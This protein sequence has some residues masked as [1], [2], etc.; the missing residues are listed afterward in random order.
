MCMFRSV[1]LE[2][3]Q[4]GRFLLSFM[5]MLTVIYAYSC[6]TFMCYVEDHEE[7]TYSNILERSKSLAMYIV[8][9][10]AM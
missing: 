7:Q 5:I 4:T 10:Y 8:F 2:N 1:N 3:V 9:P 6:D